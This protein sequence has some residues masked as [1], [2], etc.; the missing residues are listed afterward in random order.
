MLRF[1]VDGI[2]AILCITAL[3]IVGNK[4]W[5]GWIFS[6]AA[7]VSYLALGIIVPLYFLIGL[8]II[9]IGVH[10][11]NLIKWKREA[12]GEKMDL[13]ACDICLEVKFTQRFEIP[14]S[15]E[16]D[17]ELMKDYPYKTT[18]FDLC[19][20]HMKEAIDFMFKSMKDIGGEPQK[21]GAALFKWFKGK[22]KKT[23]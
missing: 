3:I 15:T 20:A 21:L 13:K 10:T 4:K 6:L 17:P 1:Y 5:W 14:I 23:E 19:P 12:R 7:A 18:S 2:G 22:T 11:R 9:L 8:N 16:T